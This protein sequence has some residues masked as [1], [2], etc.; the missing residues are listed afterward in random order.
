VV[1]LIAWHV[2][3]SAP[4]LSQSF[5]AYVAHGPVA[6]P[7]AAE[8]DAAGPAEPVCGFLQAVRPM[9]DRAATQSGSPARTIRRRKFPYF[10]MNRLPL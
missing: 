9:I 2:G 5:D 4:A 1:V 8:L 10:M 3:E 6:A 7:A